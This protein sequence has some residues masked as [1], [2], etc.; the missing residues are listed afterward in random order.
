[1]AM[2]KSEY[3]KWYYQNYRKKGIKKGRKRSTGTTGTS[4][5]AKS[6][7]LLGVS[8]VGL[9]DEGRIRGALIKEK[10]KKEMNEALKKATTDEEKEQIRLEYSRKAQQQISALKADPQ[11]AKPKKTSTRTSTSKKKKGLVVTKRTRKAT[12]T[13][14]ATAA[15][16]TPQMATMAEP[17]IS[18]EAVS[19]LTSM[20]KSLL[21]S[22]ASL[23]DEA[24]SK[25]SSTVQSILDRLKALRGK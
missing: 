24:K 3:N 22:A 17:P 21:A 14:G 19:N 20:A 11:Y 12:G 7:G 8:T 9:N 6:A 18:N 1:M 16:S 5:T 4:T 23:P 2:T 15:T 25:L 10:V 13:R